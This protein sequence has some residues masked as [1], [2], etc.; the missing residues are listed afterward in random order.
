MMDKDIKT[1]KKL[2]LKEEQKYR[3]GFD[4]QARAR[5]CLEEAKQLSFLR[6]RLNEQV[7]N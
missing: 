1:L 3:L 5:R 4:L 7:F 2:R 6:Q